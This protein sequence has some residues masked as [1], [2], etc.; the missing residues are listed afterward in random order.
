[1][2]GIEYMNVHSAKELHAKAAG[3]RAVSSR[4]AS[5]KESHA[6]A[7]EA[8]APAKKSAKRA[9]GFAAA[10]LALGWKHGAASQSPGQCPQTRWPC[11][12]GG[13]LF[14]GAQVRPVCFIDECVYL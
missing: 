13:P 6:R 3:A 1:M 10:A 11:W 5:A 8:K 2:E 7:A 14:S 9:A 12:A 4:A